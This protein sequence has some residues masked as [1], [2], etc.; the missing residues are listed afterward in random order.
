MS[1]LNHPLCNDRLAGPPGA[2]HI[3]GLHIQRYEFEGVPITASF[4]KP[5]PE[6]LLELNAGGCI[7]LHVMSRTHAPISVRTEPAESNLSAPFE[8]KDGSTVDPRSPWP[9]PAAADSE[10]GEP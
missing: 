1:P 9:F 10:G 8:L 2:P 7:A 5:S 4:W 3:P 6:E